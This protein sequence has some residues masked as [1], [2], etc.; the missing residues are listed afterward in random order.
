MIRSLFVVLY[1]SFISINSY[2][3]DIFKI[4]GGQESYVMSFKLVNNLIVIPI[5][6]NGNDLNFLLDTGVNNSIM[7]NLDIRD[8]LKLKNIQ[9]V[10]LRGLGEGDYLDAFKSTQ[11]LFRIGKIANGNH[12]IYLIPGKEFE[13]SSSLG[14]NISGIIGGDLFRDFIIEINYSSKRIKFFDPQ[15]YIYKLCKKCETFELEFYNSKPYINLSVQNKDLVKTNVKLLIDSGGSDALWLFEKSSD[16]INIPEKY[17]QDYLGKGLSGNIYGKRSKINKIIIGDYFFV[18]AN[19]AYPDSSSIES[20]YKHKERNG[21][22]GSDILKRFR[23]VYDYPNKKI[24][25]KK[26]S[27]FYNEPF[28]YNMSGIELSYSGDMLVKERQSAIS[29][30]N[31]S[32]RTSSAVEIVYNYVYAFKK[33]YQIVEIRRDSPAHK[34]GLL[35]G[36]TLLQINGKPAYNYKLPEIIHMFSNKEGKQIKLLIDRDGSVIPFKFRLEKML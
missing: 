21:S 12:M 30:D 6:V 31:N 26:K 23:I 24:T 25:F 20:A 32:Q 35:I 17:F 16:K 3:Q 8:S 36:D 15:H 19:V 22:L 9:K 5:K 13:L 1:I 28:L 18:N 2:S 10:R 29:R 11:N 14:M 4:I 7:F 34:A 27:S 33:S